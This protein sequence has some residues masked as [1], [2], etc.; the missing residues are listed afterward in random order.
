VDDSNERTTGRYAAHLQL[1]EIGRSGQERLRCRRV[2]VVGLGGLGSP[3]ALA[4]A[5]AGVGTLGLI[6]ADAVERSNLHR[7]ITYR[8][9][10]L[11]RSKV[12]V[13]AR[14]IAAL[15][16]DVTVRA[17]EARLSPSNLADRFAEFDFVIDATD[18]IATKYLVNDGAVLHDVPFSHAGVVGFQG[19][20]MTV[21]P[22]QSACIRCLFPSP[23]PD[24]EVPTCQEAGIIGALAGSIG[25]LQATEAL[26]Y[27]LGIGRLLTDRFLTYDALT[28]RWRTLTVARN[29]HCPVCGDAPTIRQLPPSEP[30]EQPC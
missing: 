12:A 29:R 18:Q 1:P 20:T 9:A 27:L 14:R 28:A 13:T 2:L 7:Q 19:Q 25:L 15:N 6:D 10:D 21:I 5:A 23:P 24:G 11:G 8:E 16:S 26:K 4:L 22:K 3:V 17:F 30:V